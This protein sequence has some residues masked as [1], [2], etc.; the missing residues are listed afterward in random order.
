MVTTK[1]IQKSQKIQITYHEEMEKKRKIKELLLTA[2]PP[3]NTRLR[4]FHK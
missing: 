2:L 4:D 1:Q 3:Q